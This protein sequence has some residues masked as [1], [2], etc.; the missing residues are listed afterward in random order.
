MSLVSDSAA[1]RLA[2]A[3]VMVGAEHAVLGVAGLHAALKLLEAALV[4]RT[5]RLDVHR[6]H[7]LVGDDCRVWNGDSPREE[8]NLCLRVRSPVLFL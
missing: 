1:D 8:S 3:R 2:V 6:F 5:E 7:L 4:D